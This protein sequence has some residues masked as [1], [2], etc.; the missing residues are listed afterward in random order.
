M[1]KHIIPVHSFDVYGVLIDQNAIGM[2]I[3]ELFRDLAS[4]SLQSEEIERRVNSY[5]ALLNKDPIALQ[6]KATIL[7][8]VYNFAI[9]RGGVLD[10]SKVFYDDTLHSLAG[11]L[12]QGQQ[13]VILGSQAFEPQYLPE[14]IARRMI[15]SFSGRKNSPDT[16]NTLAE[17]L[18]DQ[19]RLVSHSEDGLIELRAAAESGLAKRN[20]VFV[21]RSSSENENAVTEGYNVQQTLRPELYL[22][23]E[24]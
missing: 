10:F 6:E 12:D 19:H 9:N 23:M 13:V 1:I 3:I 15:G 22:A 16:F 11:I 5:H 21:N 8:E 17:K 18:E 14:E 24:G 4:G 7:D 2:Q 20:L